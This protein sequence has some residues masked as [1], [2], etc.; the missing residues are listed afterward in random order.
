MMKRISRSIRAKSTLVALIILCFS[1]VVS[2]GLATGYYMLFLNDGRELTQ[3]MVIGLLAGV[4]VS[5]AVI[6]FILLYFAAK[7]ISDPLIHMS[8]ATKEIAKGNFDVAIHHKS[9]DEL[10]TL[11]E[12]FTLMAA[13]LKTM[14]YLRKDFMSNVSHEFKTLLA[15]IQG[16]V[17]MLQNKNLPDE[18]FDQYTNILIEETGR[19]NRLC[20]N[21]LKM[22]RLDNQIIYSKSASFALDEQIRK[23]VL[24]LEEQWSKKNLDLDIGLEPVTYWGDPELLQQLWMNLI[25]NAIKYS[26]EYGSIRI[27]SKETAQEIVVKIADEGIGIAVENISR[28]FE[29][30]YQA[31][32]SHTQMGNGLGLAIAKRIVELCGGTIRCE[33]KLGDGTTFIV[34]L[35][36]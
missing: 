2:L 10:G 31:D 29:K 11:A 33:S 14:E 4:V 15:S 28:I 35:P 27:S 8:N 19:L 7:F 16:F 36:K 18:E 20:S 12:N 25:E 3:G 34:T 23:V 21:M 24:L 13:E 9:K 26:D 30:F 5:C 1:C 32:A 22:S 17:E 6:G